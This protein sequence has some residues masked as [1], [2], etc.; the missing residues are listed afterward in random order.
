MA[1]ALQPHCKP[2]IAPTWHCPVASGPRRL[3]ADDNLQSI[4]DKGWTTSSGCFIIG[5]P[6]VYILSCGNWLVTDF[7]FFQIA[8]LEPFSVL[9]AHL[10]R[11]VIGLLRCLI[12]T[13]ARISLSVDVLLR[14]RAP[15]PPPPP[16][17]P[18][19]S[20]PAEGYNKRASVK[21][22]PSP[23]RHLTI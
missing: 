21:W 22:L 2:G 9:T 3:Q 8:R 18:R 7:A 16:P 1:A 20:R 6:S 4:P 23:R 19:S 12:W 13:I 14:A 11:A 15:P 10:Q 5:L 17:P